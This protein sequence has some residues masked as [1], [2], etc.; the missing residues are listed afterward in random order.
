MK[1]E[2]IHFA[3]HGDVSTVLPGKSSL[4]LSQFS[5]FKSDDNGFLTVDEI[6]NMNIK[7]QFVNLSACETG[8]GEIFHSEGVVGL[9]EAFLQAGAQSVLATL[10]RIEDEATY[11]LM[12]N[13]YKKINV[14]TYNYCHVISDWKRDLIKDERYSHPYYW[15]SFVFWGK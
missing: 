4:V 6:S 10:W 15:G 8:L 5:D 11:N 9:K 14:K 13:F 1:Y 2:I 7:A 3:L 12:K